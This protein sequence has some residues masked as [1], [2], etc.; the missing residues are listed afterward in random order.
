MIELI[1]ISKTGQMWYL[2]KTI[3]NPDHI[4]LV[5]EDAKHNRLLSEGKIELGLNDNVTFSKVQMAAAS[6]F[7]QLTVVGDPSA[8]MEK[9][10]KNPKQ[11]LKG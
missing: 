4:V 9:I 8:I 11:L 1:T 2:N 6:G 7:N 5:T 10:N 3:V